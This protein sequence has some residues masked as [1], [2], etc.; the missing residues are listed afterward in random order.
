MTGH[1]QTSGSTRFK[2]QT[3]SQAVV[4]ISNLSHLRQA[5]PGHRLG[6]DEGEDAD[7]RASN[8]QKVTGRKPLAAGTS[9]VRCQQRGARAYDRVGRSDVISWLQ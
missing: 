8:W 5:L 2:A 9:E 1:H 7:L 4:R 6:R 3:S